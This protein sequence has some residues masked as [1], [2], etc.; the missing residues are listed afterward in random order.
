[1]S[2][3]QLASITNGTS[4][5][6]FPNGFTAASNVLFY[7]LSNT[8][9]NSVVSSFNSGNGTFTTSF[10]PSTIYSTSSFLSSNA[11][12]TNNVFTCKT[13]GIYKFVLSGNYYFASST[14]ANCT[15]GFYFK[16]TSAVTANSIGYTAGNGTGPAC[17]T[18][19]NG[20]GGST[21]AELEIPMKVGDTV[22]P[23][24]YSS[25][26]SGVSLYLQYY[27]IRQVC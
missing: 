10:T 13:A 25:S 3:I 18:G 27:M 12:G 21:G 2:S 6:N 11:L 17:S 4:S 8:T 26:T 9:I 5:P 22:Q 19:A 20:S 23:L 14:S 16:Q 24:Y 7:T 15:V 1:M